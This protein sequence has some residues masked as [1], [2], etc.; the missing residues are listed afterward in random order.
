M[1]DPTLVAFYTSQLEQTS[2]VIIY[3]KFLEKMVLPEQRTSGLTAAEK[4]SLPVEEI[5]KRIVETYRYC[6]PFF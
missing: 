5:T 2:Q 6:P 1:N 3:S 4:F